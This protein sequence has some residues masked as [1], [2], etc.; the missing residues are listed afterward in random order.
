MASELL[1]GHMILASSVLG[2]AACWRWLVADQAPAGLLAAEGK[3]RPA[4]DDRTFRE[5]LVVTNDAAW[6][7][8]SEKNNAMLSARLAVMAGARRARSGL[9]GGFGAPGVVPGSCGPGV[10]PRGGPGGPGLRGRLVPQQT[11][12]EA[13]LRKAVGNNAPEAD[14]Q[15]ALVTVRAEHKAKGRRPCKSA[16]CL[17]RPVE[18]PA[19]GSK[20][21]APGALSQG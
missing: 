17:A 14:I 18:S 15:A 6:A 12:A 7:A 19:G 16:G 3:F 4:G 13:A 9:L 8:I 11:E 10:P 1:A 20:G 5:Q 21:R 2:C